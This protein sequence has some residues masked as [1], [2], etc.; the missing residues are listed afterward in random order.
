MLSEMPSLTLNM[1]R[2]RLSQPW[3]SST[4]R[5]YVE[6]LKLIFDE[7]G[8]SEKNGLNLMV[9]SNFQFVKEDLGHSLT[10]LG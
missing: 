6:C 4:S 9:D 8:R 2:G 3:M 10:H 1:P 5:S 7:I